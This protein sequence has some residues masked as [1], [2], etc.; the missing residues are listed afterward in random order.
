MFND[1][2]FEHHFVGHCYIRSNYYD[3]TLLAR[4]PAMRLP[5]SKA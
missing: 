4:M 2:I 1:H 3:D 5:E